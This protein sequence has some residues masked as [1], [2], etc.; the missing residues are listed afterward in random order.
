VKLIDVSTGR[1]IDDVN[2]AR[3]VALSLAR[4][5]KEDQIVYGDEKGG[6][7][8]HKMEPRGGR[9]AEGD[10][11]EHSFLREC[12]RLPGAVPA[13]AWSADGSLIAAGCATGEARVFKAADG[14]KAAT[15]KAG[16]GAIFSIAF[17]PESNR[18]ATGG[19]DGEV[20]L[21]DAKSGRAAAHVYARPADCPHRSA[22]ASGFKIITRRG[23]RAKAIPRLSARR[24][25]DR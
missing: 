14:K 9:L 24:S 10:D 11:K 7:R 5:P 16:E 4:N 12:E 19:D 3:D 6:V 18:V 25:L 8:I 21:F 13:L 23:W 2:K 1:L 17:D 22:V 15:L 20:R